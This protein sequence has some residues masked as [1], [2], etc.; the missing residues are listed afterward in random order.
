V[1][2]GKLWNNPASLGQS[3]KTSRGVQ[4]GGQDT[5]CIRRGILVD[6][7][8]DFVERGLRRL[9]PRYRAPISHLR[10]ISASTLAWE[11]V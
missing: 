8:N 6:V 1:R 5:S 9:G 3:L 11:I 10:R 4:R 2:V 7:G